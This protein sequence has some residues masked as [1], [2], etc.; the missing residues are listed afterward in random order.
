MTTGLVLEIEDQ[1]QLACYRHLSVDVD[2][3]LPSN[4]MNLKKLS[5]HLV[6]HRHFLRESGKRCFFR[7][8]GPAVFLALGEAVK[9]VKPR[10]FVTPKDQRANGPIINQIAGP[11]ALRRFTDLATWAFDPGYVNCWTFGP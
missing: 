11:L 1:A 4:W 10:E 9:P 8:K 5:D 3:M 6:G 2:T 7:A